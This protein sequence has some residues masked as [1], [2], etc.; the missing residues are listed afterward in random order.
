MKVSM[1]NNLPRF[2]NMTDIMGV[3]KGPFLEETFR[4]S[5]ESWQIHSSTGLG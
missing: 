3:K 1:G 2:Q 4:C 5:R